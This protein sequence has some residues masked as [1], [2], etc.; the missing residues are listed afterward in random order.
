[1]SRFH[2]HILYFS[3]PHYWNYHNLV[4]LGFSPIRL[5]YTTNNPRVEEFFPFATRRLRKVI[6]KGGE[7]YLFHLKLCFCGHQPRAPFGNL[8]ITFMRGVILGQEKHIKWMPVE[9]HT[10]LR[11]LV[12]TVIPNRDEYQVLLRPSLRIPEY[13]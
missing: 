4:P 7:M 9:E 5:V 1:M 6:Q 13:K 10:T 3:V 2:P 8:R 12:L 11:G